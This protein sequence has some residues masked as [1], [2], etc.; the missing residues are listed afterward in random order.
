[1]QKAKMSN[2]KCPECGGHQSDNGMLAWCERGHVYTLPKD[3]ARAV[4]FK[5]QQ[6]RVFGRRATDGPGARK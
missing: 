4:A 2:Y 1:M 3:D 5:V 6:D